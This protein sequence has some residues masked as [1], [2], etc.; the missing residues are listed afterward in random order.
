MCVTCAVLLAEAVMGQNL[1]SW[2]S[3]GL[4]TNFTVTYEFTVRQ[5]HPEDYG[6]FR[7]FSIA[8]IMR[9]VPMNNVLF[10]LNPGSKDSKFS[11]VLRVSLNEFKPLE[12]F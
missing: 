10:N 1:L 2:V 4:C 6:R 3:A 8:I 5:W 7:L 12:E 9:S 11:H